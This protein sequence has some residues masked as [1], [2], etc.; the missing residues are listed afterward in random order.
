MQRNG[1]FV[2]FRQNLIYDN[3]QN[4]LQTF[5]GVVICAWIKHV[6]KNKHGNAHKKH[7]VA[8]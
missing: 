4:I 1:N 2:R 6:N 7:F 3:Y 5:C 8:A